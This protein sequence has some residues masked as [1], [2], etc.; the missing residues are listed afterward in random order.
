MPD[1]PFSLK[2]YRLLLKLFPAGFREEYAVSME[3]EFRAELAESA[4]ALRLAALW[5][6]LLVDL[7]R[8]IPFQLLRE[9]RQ[10]A[11]HTL[12]LWSRL[13]ERT[14]L[15]DAALSEQ[16]DFNLGSAQDIV[17]A[18]VAQTSWNF[19]SML[20]TQPVLGRGFSAG[21]DTRGRNAAAVIGYGLWQQMF[22]GDGRALGSVIHVNGMPLTIIGVAL[23]GFD[24]PNKTVLWKAADF[25][26]GNNGWET[27]AR[28][29]PDVTWSQ[30]RSAF[31]AEAA[32]LLLLAGVALILLIAC[33]NVANLLLARTADRAAEMSIRSA[34][35]ASRAR[36]V[37]Q[38]LTECLILSSVAAVAGL[39]V[40][41]WTTSI[42]VKL[43]PAPLAAQSY[44]ILDGHVLGFC[45][46]CIDFEWSAFPR[47]AIIGRGPHP[48]VR[49]ARRYRRTPREPDSRNAGG[50]TSNAY[51]HSSCSVGLSGARVCQFA[52]NRSR[53]RFARA[54]Y[55]ERFIR[56]HDS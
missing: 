32:S 42:A 6:R 12:R 56:R 40:G 45:S 49:L 14:Y 22:A 41:F 35:G 11:R 52:R 5:M 1:A 51:H 8:S 17:R 36:I 50:G 53:L 7:A 44:S 47:L 20:G 46:G 19:F 39:A 27:I 10:D 3:R 28:L 2:V 15:D 16:A 18:H 31:A 30:A 21:E 54:G 48:Y 13:R 33:A 38:L 43:Q 23:T 55:G 25:T 37:Q 24:Y 9:I 29:K 4:G 34:L 26:P